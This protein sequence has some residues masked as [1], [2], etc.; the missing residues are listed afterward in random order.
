MPSGTAAPS[1]HAACGIAW[2]LLAVACYATMDATTRWL[3]PA[4]GV[5]LMMVVRYAVQTIA[6]ASWLLV[7]SA[8]GA[9]VA[10]RSHPGWQGLRGVV[11]FGSAGLAVLALQGMPVAEYTAVIMVTPV[12]VTLLARLV[13]GHRVTALQ[14]WLVAGGF[15]GAL[16]VIRPGSGLF[17]SAAMLALGVALCNAGYQTVTNRFG[18]GEDAVTSNFHAGWIGLLLSCVWL[19]SSGAAAAS[20]A[21][22]QAST[23]SALFMLSTMAALATIAQLALVVALS[24][25]PAATLMPF[26]Y[27]QIGVATLAGWGLLGD[28]PDAWTWT[29]MAVIAGCGVAG[30]RAAM[31]PVVSLP[32]LRSA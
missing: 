2:L 9:R 29:G 1:P 10:H 12:L 4:F 19:I 15:A 26:I 28:V 7:R 20:W 17:E 27:A 3:G 11:L 22:L 31:R 24:R 8:R 13:L 16:I 23:T 21:T 6:M 14:G 32:S 30:A 5:P 25:A 18:A